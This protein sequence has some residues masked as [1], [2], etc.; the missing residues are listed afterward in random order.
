MVRPRQRIIQLFS[1]HFGTPP[2]EVRDLPAD[3]SSRRYYRLSG[4]DERTAIGALG[5]DPA[6]N[7][8]FLSFSRALRSAGLNVPEI[9]REDQSSGVWLA[10]DLGDA[11]LF[12]ALEEARRQSRERFP[13]EIEAL[14]RRALTSLPRFQIEGGRVVDFGV[15]H[16]R[17]HFDEQSILW[18]LNYFKYHFLKLAHVPF[19]E[20]RLEEDFR[21]LAGVALQADASHFMHR[22]FQSRNIML[23]GDECWF[24]D[25]QGGRQ[26]ALQYDVASLLFSGTAGVPAEARARLLEAYLDALEREQGVDRARWREHYRAF[27]LIRLMQAMGAYGYRGL[28]ERRPT[29]LR[30]IPN[31]ARTL[32]QLLD[33]GLP[34]RLPELEGVFGRIV[35][36]RAADA[37]GESA[38]AR[39]QIAERGLTIQLTSFSYRRG[40]PQDFG[41]HGGGFVF[42][43]RALPNPGREER[44]R[45]LSG[46]DASVVEHLERHQEVQSFWESTRQLVEAQIENY[47]ERDFRSLVIAFGCTGGQHRSVYF[48]ERLARHLE[49]RFPRVTVS[50]S[51]REREVWARE[52]A[53]S[54]GEE[55][56]EKGPGNEVGQ[57]GG[58]EGGGD[59]AEL[60]D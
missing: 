18:D 8:A 33:E 26:G 41:E 55:T 4:P 37:P 57:E 28:F 21:T 27:A 20:A 35:E 13:P 52:E 15:S 46:L 24:I 48:V 45:T 49:D 14:F 1:E 60:G 34:A 43:C 44:Y 9:Y 22:D 36:R 19:D 29:F 50:V 6:E 58:G 40:Y 59:L 38:E 32:A 10:E 54:G 2:S 42:D 53:E 7:R 11:T 12:G 51:H 56:S 3:G 39:G 31:A 16:P 5:P 23:R 30:G 47:L 17:A 25:Y